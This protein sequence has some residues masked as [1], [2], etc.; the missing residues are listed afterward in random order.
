MDTREAR[1]LACEVK[2]LVD[3]ERARQI[4]DWARTCLDPDPHGSG[5]HADEYRITSLYFDT[6]D[7]DVFNRQGSFGRAKYRIRRYANSNVVFLERKMRTS[8]FLTKRRTNIAIEDLECLNEDDAREGWSGRW[9]HRRLLARRLQ[10]TCQVSYTRMAR[11]GMTDLGPI[12]LTLDDHLRT[13]RRGTLEFGG[14]TGAPVL[15]RQL[16]LELKFR[17]A[18]PAAFK[19]LVEE[20]VLNPQPVSKYRFSMMALGEAGPSDRLSQPAARV[21]ALLYA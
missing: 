14:S 11:L 6:T 3:P 17:V 18:M 4:R 7:F 12:R 19:R 10:P 15:Q 20:F 16:I 2:F 9:F 1:A 5:A 13:D 8:A 21:G